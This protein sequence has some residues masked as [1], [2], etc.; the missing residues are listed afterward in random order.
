MGRK[1]DG[2][3]D[4]DG[5]GVME[6]SCRRCTMT[7]DDRKTYDGRCRD[8]SAVMALHFFSRWWFQIFFMFNPI[9]GR[10]PIWLKFSDGLKPPTSFSLTQM[11]FPPIGYIGIH[12]CVSMFGPK[13][14]QLPDTLGE[15][16]CQWWWGSLENVGVGGGARIVSSQ[17]SGF[18][19][20]Y[21]W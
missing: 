1:Q 16:C 4:E 10:F 3:S 17:Q 6:T 18:W 20:G 11:L 12:R 15:W 8:M 5:R 9:W 14:S 7:L 21:Y 2:L 19:N 13:T